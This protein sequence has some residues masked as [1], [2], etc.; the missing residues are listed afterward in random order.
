FSPRFSVAGRQLRAPL[1]STHPPK[2]DTRKPYDTDP[3]TPRPVCRPPARRAR[4]LIRCTPSHCT[5][6]L[7]HEHGDHAAA[8]QANDRHQTTHCNISPAPRLCLSS[9]HLNKPPLLAPPSRY[10]LSAEVQSPPT[11]GRTAAERRER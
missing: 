8:G 11:A 4:L 1:S 6:N 2:R 9:C 3:R 7:R 5:D 10:R